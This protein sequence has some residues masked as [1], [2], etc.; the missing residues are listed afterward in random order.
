MVTFIMSGRYSSKAMEGMSKSR[1]T[2]C[3][4]L[5]KKHGGEVISLY[6]VLGDID[7]LFVVNFPGIEQAMKASVALSKETR[8]SFTTAPAVTVD[9]FDE[10]MGDV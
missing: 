6:A 3:N 1:T 9:A 5:I 4:E 7:L 10:M 2:K 8:I